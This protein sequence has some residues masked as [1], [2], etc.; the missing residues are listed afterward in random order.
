MGLQSVSV[1]LKRLSFWKEKEQRE[2]QAVKGRK[3]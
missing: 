2:S 1:L 3:A